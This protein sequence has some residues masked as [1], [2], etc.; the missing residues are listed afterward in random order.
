MKFLNTSKE[1]FTMQSNGKWQNES[2]NLYQ[3]VSTVLLHVKNHKIKC[4]S[5]LYCLHNIQIYRQF[6]QKFTIVYGVRLVTLKVYNI[7][8]SIEHSCC[9]ITK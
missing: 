8:L 6:A 3:N 5:V 4:I 1:I 7:H 2:M 9:F